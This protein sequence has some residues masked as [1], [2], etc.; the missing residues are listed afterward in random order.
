[1]RSS[2]KLARDGFR[3]MVGEFVARGDVAES[4]D[5]NGVDGFWNQVAFAGYV[6]A[7]GGERHA[8]TKL[9]ADERG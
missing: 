8:K 4:R 7:A 1:M 2:N 5:R 3:K 6:V 9:A